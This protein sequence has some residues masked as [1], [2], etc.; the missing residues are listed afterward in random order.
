MSQMT[1][2]LLITLF[3]MVMFIW[4]K[5]PFGVTTMTCCLLLAASGCIELGTAFTGFGNKI[6]VLIAP[7][8]A[9][10]QVLTKTAV[11]G[12]VSSSLNGLKGKKGIALII[13]FYVVA[14]VFSQFIPSTAALTI[15]IVFLT[16]LDN[17]GDITAN[18][19]ILPL[20]GVMC[21]WKFRLP[22]GMGA[23]TFATLNA[24]YEGII[25]DPTYAISMLDPFKFAI[26]PITVLTLYC[27]F[28][29]R[30]MPKNKDVDTSKLKVQSASELLPES[31]QKIVYLVFIGV[32]LV[33]LL[34]QWTGNWLYLAPAAGVI[35]L[36]VTGCLNVQ[37]ASKAMTVDMVWMLAGVL[38][39]ADALG[40]SGAGEL[41][42]QTLL[43]LLGENPTSFQI[44]L[45]FSAATVIMTTFISNMG[46]QSVLIPIAA[47]LA[48]AAGW[49]PRG[50]VLIIG[51]ANYFA[52][53]FPSGAGECAVAFA[54]GEYNPLKVMKFTVPYMVLAI[55]SC[56]ISAQ[57][58]YPLG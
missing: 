53:G 38:I 13:A 56:A 49:D 15:L 22:I 57:L 50:I 23:S 4:H 35:I 44:F 48:L 41:I 12:K 26:I 33:M 16:T 5:V 9:L 46:T 34:N 27:I 52:V 28:F 51:T 18:R 37:D 42:G 20:L 29:W 8:L 43:R 17:S 54:A 10:S 31:K 45:M 25:T 14:A 47:S 2:V 36:I 3:M 1:I 32:V 21:A 7:M 24:F 11:V 58:F 6:V 19:L 40:K 55:V 39:V 30:S